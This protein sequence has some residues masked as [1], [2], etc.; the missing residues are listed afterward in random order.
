MAVT[1]AI[2]YADLRCFHSRRIMA[3][4]ASL[5]TW[6]CSSPVSVCPVRTNARTPACLSACCSIRRLRMFLSF[7][8]NTHLRSPTMEAS[9]HPAF[10]CQ[11]YQALEPAPYVRLL[12]AYWEHASEIHTHRRRTHTFHHAA[13]SSVSSH[14]IASSISSASRPYSSASSAKVSP[15]QNRSAISS[16]GILV[17]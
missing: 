4:S 12:V 8:T 11:K 9:L 5:S 17:P 3:G 13:L 7:V 10:R 15:A 16:V 14:L 2:K 6:A 1:L